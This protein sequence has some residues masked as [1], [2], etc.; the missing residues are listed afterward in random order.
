MAV[1]VC[2]TC[3]KRFLS[4]RSAGSARAI[5]SRHSREAHGSVASRVAA[6]A[7]RR[8]TNREHMRIVRRGTRAPSALAADSLRVFVL[9]PLRRELHQGLYTRTRSAFVRT[10]VPLTGIV[11]LQG[12]DLHRHRLPRKCVRRFAH[13]LAREGT[14]K[15]SEIVTLSLLHAFAD[16]AGRWLEHG[17]E[18]R[19]A[20]FSEDDCRFSASITSAVL[21][22][23]ALA[24][25]KRIG[26]LGYHRRRGEPR[27]GAHLLSFT[28]ESLDTFGQKAG[29]Y[30][31]SRM[32]ALDTLLYHMWRDGYVWIPAASLAYQQ[33]HAARG[34]H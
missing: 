33:V 15:R 29:S 4:K 19:V 10:G 23:A 20:L 16:R 11:R 28:R 30:L 3:G 32:L 34:R 18:Q 21:L 31:Q 13:L 2:R 24:A 12:C 6:I 5:L 27:Y 26:W 22:S 7:R 17:T 9:C 25:G 1:S 8:G 14:G